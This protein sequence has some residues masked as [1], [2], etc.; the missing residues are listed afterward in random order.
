MSCTLENDFFWWKRGNMDW[1][2]VS[3]Q[4]SYVEILTFNMMVMKRQG[5]WEVVRSW[6]CS[7]HD[8]VSALTR[9]DKGRWFFS[10]PCA[11]ARRK[12]PSINQEEGINQELDQAGTLIWDFQPPELWEINICC[13]R[14]LV[15]G[16]LLQQS[17]LRRGRGN[18]SWKDLENEK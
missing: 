18:G 13:L 12:Q 15:Y 3:S 16:L 1:I 11:D 8:G 14:H 5:L 2:F 17:K 4:H 6:G 7:P 10:L 9:W